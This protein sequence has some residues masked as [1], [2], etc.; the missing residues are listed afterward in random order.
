ME[1][2]LVPS[3][4]IPEGSELLI[5]E[6]A[7]AT[8]LHLNILEKI[9]AAGFRIAISSASRDQAAALVSMERHTQAGHEV[10]ERIRSFVEKGLASRHIQLLPS[11]PLNTS[12]ADLSQQPTYQLVA[13]ISGSRYDYLAIDDRFAHKVGGGEIKFLNSL[14]LLRLSRS[15]DLVSDIDLLEL[16]T[17]LRIAQFTLVPPDQEELLNLVLASGISD[18]KL[19]ESAELRSFKHN[20]L[21]VR[22]TN[23]IVLPDDA[24]DFVN[25]L[26][27]IR[28]CIPKIWKSETD[29]HVAGIK[30]DWLVSL[31]DIR[32][33]AHLLPLKSSGQIGLSPGRQMFLPILVSSFELDQQDRKRQQKWLWDNHLKPMK[34]N[35]PALFQDFLESTKELFNLRAD[36]SLMEDSIPSPD[37]E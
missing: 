3:Q 22:A 13:D 1:Q 34:Q 17:R 27:A 8:L 31:V 7:L 33:W 25:L 28:S 18:D 30:S 19:L 37:N 36:E 10:V 14:G 29:S 12:D 9:R 20:L 11:P 16:R 32:D 15:C 4:G 5:D 35:S 23:F 2:P 26:S 24:N 6:V 21:R